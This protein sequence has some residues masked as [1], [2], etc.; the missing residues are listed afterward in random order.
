MV[1]FVFF[2]MSN[3]SRRVHY[4]LAAADVF[5][6]LRGQ[7]RFFVHD[8]RHVMR[9][10]LSTNWFKNGSHDD[11]STSQVTCFLLIVGKGMAENV[12]VK[13]EQKLSPSVSVSFSY[14]FPL[15]EKCHESFSLR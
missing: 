14:F 10:N 1:S 3:T 8:K 7:T 4:R 5:D 9:K 12:F 15:R 11:D 2:F 6:T 13:K